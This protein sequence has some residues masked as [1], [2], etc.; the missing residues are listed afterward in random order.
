VIADGFIAAGG[1]RRNREDIGQRVT[2][3]AKGIGVGN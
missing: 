1:R 3:L 2:T